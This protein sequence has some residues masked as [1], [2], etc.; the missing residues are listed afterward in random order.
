[1]APVKIYPPADPVLA[2]KV[3]IPVAGEWFDR[4]DADRLVGA[5]LA[6]RGAPSGPKTSRRPPGGSSP[7]SG[8]LQPASGDAGREG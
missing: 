7:R 8:R 1:M 3:G 5:G 2:G 6:A 4:P